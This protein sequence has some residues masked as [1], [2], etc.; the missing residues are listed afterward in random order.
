MAAPEHILRRLRQDRLDEPSLLELEYMISI[1]DIDPERLSA[2]CAESGWDITPDD[3]RA[4]RSVDI[5]QRV[6]QS[7]VTDVEIREE[8]V[9]PNDRN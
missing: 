2:A 9:Q 7:I 1:S 4:E 5:I 6:P 8:E 3:I